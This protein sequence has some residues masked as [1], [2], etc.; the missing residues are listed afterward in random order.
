MLIRLTP[1][2][3]CLA[4]PAPAVRHLKASIIEC[5]MSFTLR[6]KSF[7]SIL[8]ANMNINTLQTLIFFFSPGSTSSDTNGD[9][10]FLDETSSVKFSVWVSFCEIYNENIHDLLDVV[11]NG[12]HRRNVLR[13]SQ[14]VKGNAFVKGNQLF[15][16]LKIIISE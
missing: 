4:C 3:L 7:L 6:L 12:S 14:D 9:S 5:F 15:S 10:V 16:G 2:K 13:L 1:R 8:S 11:P